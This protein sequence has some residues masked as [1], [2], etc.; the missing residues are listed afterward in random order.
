MDVKR[1]LNFE[2]VRSE[3]NLSTVRLDRDVR[4]EENVGINAGQSLE[5]VLRKICEGEENKI[6]YLMSH[7]I[8]VE[9][10]V[11]DF[12]TELKEVL[13]ETALETTVR[14]ISKKLNESYTSRYR[15]SL[16]IYSCYQDSILKEYGSLQI[17]KPTHS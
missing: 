10:D 5:A 3:K 13:K 14:F 15:D 7:A 8:P 9:L 17:K 1:Y 16:F 11:N 12:Q 6:S 4:S 2:K